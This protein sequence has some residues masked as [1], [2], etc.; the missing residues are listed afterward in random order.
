MHAVKFPNLYKIHE[1]NTLDSIKLAKTG[2]QLYRNT[3][4]DQ[5][6]NIQCQKR[7][8]PPSAKTKRF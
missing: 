4:S 3:C 8:N 5:K 7:N 6:R 1:K 2:V